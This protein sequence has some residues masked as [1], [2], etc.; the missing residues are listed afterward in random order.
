MK[1]L[2]RIILTVLALIGALA[3]AVFALGHFEQ[4]SL[5]FRTYEELKASDLIGRG[6]VT[7]YLPHS[8]TDIQ[9]S[10]DI[11]FNYAWASFKSL[12]R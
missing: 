10:H 5:N 1:V 8:A 6:W 9:E 7:P 3:L 4:V 2:G 12:F 11:D